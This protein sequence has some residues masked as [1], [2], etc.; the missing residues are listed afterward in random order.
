[1]AD[2]KAMNLEW[3]KVAERERSLAVDLDKMKVAESAESWA[4]WWG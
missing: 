3:M 1:M 4:D 2:S